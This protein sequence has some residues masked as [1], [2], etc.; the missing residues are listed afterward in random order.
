MGCALALP[1][2]AGVELRLAHVEHLLPI[3]PERANA[4][5]PNREPDDGFERDTAGRDVVLALDL[6]RAGTARDVEM[7]EVRLTLA[8]RMPVESNELG[9]VEGVKSVEVGH[10][11]N[12][13]AAGTVSRLDVAVGVQHGEFQAGRSAK[14]GHI[15]WKLKRYELNEPKIAGLDQDV[16]GDARHGALQ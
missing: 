11:S 5:L 12:V 2:S 10:R 4:Q 16:P 3:W 13:N 7:G 14:V 8:I 15:A 6:W 9:A 1:G